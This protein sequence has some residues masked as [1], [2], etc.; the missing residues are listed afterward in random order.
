MF[1]HPLISLRL[2]F[3]RVPA[4][5]KSL[6]LGICCLT[7]S[8]S[9]VTRA[10][11]LPVDGGKYGDDKCLKVVDPCLGDKKVPCFTGNLD[12][13]G[14]IKDILCDK[15]DDKLCDKKPVDDHK[16]CKIDFK[17]HDHLLCDI[18]DKGKDHCDLFVDHC[19][20]DPC[21]HA[22]HEP[23]CDPAAVSAP[24]SAAF[25]GLVIAGIMLMVGLKARKSVIC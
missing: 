19:D 11:I 23:H 5:F 25:G 22:S 12:L 17:G 15:G 6:G 8:I 1:A 4:M 9:S 24:A 10:S 3:E 7:L 14:D 16:D 21:G 20:Y 2:I 13:K 18:G